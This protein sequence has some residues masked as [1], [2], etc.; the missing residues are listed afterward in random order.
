MF[1]D[2]ATLFHENVLGA[3]DD[4]LKTK[5]D[6]SSGRSRDTKAALV[7]ANA[8]FHFR[9][10]LPAQLRLTRT[11]L[12]KSCPDYDLLADVVNI[13]KH[14]T[15]NRGNPQI[16]SVED[17]E[18]QIV[19][20]EYQDDLGPYRHNAKAI[21]LK[22]LDGSERDLLDVMTNVLN[23]WL[24]DLRRKGV[25][26]QSPRYQVMGRSQPIPREESG[27][28]RITLEMVQGLR[29]KQTFRLQR[30]NAQTGE[31]ERID[32]TGSKATF[33]IYKPRYTLDLQLTNE[34]SGE[35]LIASVTLSDEESMELSGLETR[36]DQ[37]RFIAELPRA[38]QALAQLA[39][40]ANER[41]ASGGTV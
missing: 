8:L 18:E 7:A 20:T 19:V 39:S 10:H 27:D 14:R 28:G 11:T 1:D 36:E 31:L 26:T 34:D 37:E 17:I 38:Q 13:S 3:Y 35:R 21:T 6:P 5:S 41:N 16:V 24:R 23:F 2:L 32:L 40:E 22:L 15:L 30:Y 4:Y 9:E 12:T 25:I 29:F 33:R